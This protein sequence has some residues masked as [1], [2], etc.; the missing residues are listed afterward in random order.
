MNENT[1]R[2]LRLMQLADSALPIGALA[3][4]YGLEML[5]AEGSLHVGNLG[6][7]L[8][9]YLIE[10]GHLEANYCQAAHHCYH[11]SLIVADWLKVNVELDALKLARESREASS[12]LGRRFLQLLEK[13]EP[14]PAFDAAIRACRERAIGIHYCTAFGLACGVI[15][16]DAESGAVAYLQQSIAGLV[17]ACQRLLPLGQTE[18][19]RLLWDI[20]P[21]IVA[22]VR[23][24]GNPFVFTAALETAS[25]R[26]PDLTT[27]LFIS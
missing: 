22:A 15:G 23:P 6:N 16:V 8:H 2:W 13:L 4:S 10:T 14:H 24:E 26:H 12:T 20:K 19:S 11:E 9:D 3:H 17:S 18:A 21:A 27:R 5:V 7:F 1:L 25:M